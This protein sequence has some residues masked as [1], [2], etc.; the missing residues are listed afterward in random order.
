MLDCLYRGKVA[1]FVF[2]AEPHMALSVVN[3]QAQALKDIILSPSQKL[4]KAFMMIQEGENLE[5][6]SF[7][8]TLLMINLL[9]EQHWQ[10][11]FIKIS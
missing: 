6:E 9:V 4:Y 11:I 8:Y 3:H 1:V 7:S 5:K 2:K 10:G